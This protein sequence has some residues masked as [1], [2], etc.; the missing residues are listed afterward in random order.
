TWINPNWLF[1]WTIFQLY[2]RFGDVVVV[3]IKALV[4]AVAAG[5]LLGIRYSGPTQWWTNLC[6]LTAMVAIS[7][8]LAL[9]PQIVSLALFAILLWICFQARYRRRTS[10]LY[11]AV[12]LA[13]LWANLDVT[14]AMAAFFLF[15]L[16][17]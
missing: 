16:A 11:F 8:Q 15:L 2:A 5:F 1:D 4:G 12:P 14:Y 10:V 17:V 7:V 9:T 6:V 3:V 13:I